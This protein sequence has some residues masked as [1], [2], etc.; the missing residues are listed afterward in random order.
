VPVPMNDPTNTSQSGLFGVSGEMATLMRS[1]DWSA[2][3]LGP[4][5]TWPHSLRT[6]VRVLLTS[7][8]AMWMTWGPDLT[9]LY[10][11]AYAAMTLGAKHPWA[12]GRPAQE[13][14]A[15]IWPEIGPRIDQVLQTGE[16]TWDEDLLLY[17]ERSGYPEETYHTFSYS[18]IADDDGRVSGHLF[19]VTEQTDRVIGER[20]MALL[21]DTGVAIAATIAESELFVAIERALSASEDL[22]FTLIYLTDP[23]SDEAHLVCRAGMSPDHPAALASIPMDGRDALWPV[24]QVVSSGTGQ[25]VALAD[26]AV[27]SYGRRWQRPVTHVMVMPMTQPGLRRPVGIIVAGLNPARPIDQPYCGFVALLVAQLTAGVANAHAYAE[28]RRRVQALAELDRSKTTFF[29]NVSHEFR[30]P[31][32][33][34]LGPLERVMESSDALSGP[35]RDQIDLAHRNGIRLLKLV[36]TLLDF[37]RIEAGR[38]RARFAPT[39]LGAL[40]TDLASAFRS[41]MET[42]GLTYVVESEPLERVQVHAIGQRDRV[43]D[44][45]GRPG[46]P[47]RERHGRR[48]S[49]RRAAPR[50]RAV[51]PGGRRTGPEPRRVRHRARAGA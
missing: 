12:L 35:V 32:T 18:P 19:V 34:L 7:R 13:V 6:V 41:A 36:N 11:D 15:E 40:T 47:C 39:D 43:P 38:M 26:T 48:H 27:G 45:A 50:V 37:S 24:A 3:P 42:A 5:D 22:P 28:E 17:L 44:T 29:S 8:F 33:L 9:V 31:L 46:G 1:R 21:R 10:N 14:W 30:T 4:V 49:A 25:V 2:T 20:R 51:P 16:A 23:D